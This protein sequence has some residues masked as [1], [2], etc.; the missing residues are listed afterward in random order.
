VWAS[1]TRPSAGHCAHPY[2]SVRG[3]VNRFVNK[4]LRNTYLVLALEL[5]EGYV[6]DSRPQAAP[7]C[8][9][10][11][12]LPVPLTPPVAGQVGERAA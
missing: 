12:C 8:Y 3:Y 7:E 4:K 5:D 2:A 11:A 1:P 10:R 9:A 6:I